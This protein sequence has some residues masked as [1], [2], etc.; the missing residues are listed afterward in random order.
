MTT[1]NNDLDAILYIEQEENPDK[2]T[3]I[4]AWQRLVDTGLIWKLQGFYGRSASLMI[5]AGILTRPE[6]RA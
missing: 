2:E 3:F 6:D 4:A 1:F 5:E